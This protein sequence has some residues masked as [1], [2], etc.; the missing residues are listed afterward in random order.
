MSAC[1]YAQSKGE[2]HR[3]TCTILWGKKNIMA[4]KVSNELQKLLNWDFHQ[5][6]QRSIEHSSPVY[7]QFQPIVVW[8]TLRPLS[9]PNHSA[10]S[11]IQERASM[12]LYWDLNYWKEYRCLSC[13]FKMRI[14]WQ[15]VCFLWLN[16]STRI[17]WALLIQ[18]CL[19][20]PFL[21]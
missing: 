14:Q 8:N 16:D 11:V 5:S 12:F 13:R 20:L 6:N 7:I 1:F 4:A 17:C 18:R 2:F 10:T 19:R 9:S 21:V 15:C 3:T